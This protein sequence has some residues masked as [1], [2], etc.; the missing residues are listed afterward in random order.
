MNLFTVADLGTNLTLYLMVL[1][2]SLHTHWSIKLRALL[3]WFSTWNSCS[4]SWRETC[5]WRW[6]KTTNT[7]MCTS[8]RGRWADDR[9]D[10]M[11]IIHKLR[12]ENKIF[13]ARVSLPTSCLDVSASSSGTSLSTATG[14]HRGTGGGEETTA[15][16]NWLPEVSIFSSLFYCS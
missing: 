12:S 10:R 7:R 13:L 2:T 5:V 8:E 3:F 6:L 1:T 11:K 14:Q 16:W 9:T 15:D 4:I